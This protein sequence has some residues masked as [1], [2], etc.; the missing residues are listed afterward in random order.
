MYKW[1]DDMDII[2]RPFTF[3]LGAV[4]LEEDKTKIKTIY[5]VITLIPVLLLN[6]SPYLGID[7]PKEIESDEVYDKL[8]F[9]FSIVFVL[10][11]LGLFS[12]YKCIVLSE[13]IPT[14]TVASFLFLLYSASLYAMGYFF[15]SGYLGST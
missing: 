13:I 5:W 9:G 6:L 12:S 7:I 1:R 2:E 8:V 10:F 3:N 15:F 14:K 11:L 4:P